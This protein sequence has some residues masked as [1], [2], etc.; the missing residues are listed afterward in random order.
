MGLISLLII[1]EINSTLN[2]KIDREVIY[3]KRCNL[4]F[5]IESV[6]GKLFLT[7][8]SLLFYSHGVNISSR[9]KFTV[10]DLKEITNIEKCNT[11][12]LIP[13]GM[14]IHSNSKTYQFVVPGRSKWIE[15]IKNTCEKL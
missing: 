6:G 3:E 7:K 8:D 2:K 11:L 14:K 1:D 4:F 13:N 12:L 15:I 10:I 5:G 9:R